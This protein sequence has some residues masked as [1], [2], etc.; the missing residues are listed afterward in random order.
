MFSVSSIYE[1]MSVEGSGRV[2]LAEGSNLS[3]GEIVSGRCDCDCN[4]D[5]CV[6]GLRLPT[7]VS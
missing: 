4:C 6:E 1:Q 3:K 5:C 7:V 2:R